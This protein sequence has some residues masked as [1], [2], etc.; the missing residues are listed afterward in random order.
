MCLVGLYS[1]VSRLTWVGWTDHYNRFKRK[2]DVR[3][4]T[5]S[6][7]FNFILCPY[8][9]QINCTLFWMSCC[10]ILAGAQGKQF[11]LDE[12]I[13]WALGWE[14]WAR[15]CCTGLLDSGWAMRG[16]SAEWQACIVW[17][18]AWL[19]QLINAPSSISTEGV[20]Q[21]SVMRSCFILSHCRRCVL[22]EHVGMGTS[23]SVCVFACPSLTASVSQ[24]LRR[25]SDLRN[26]LISTHWWRQ[27]TE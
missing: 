16:N 22:T 14:S 8:F 18:M 15:G 20:G 17:P 13:C 9:R 25:G 1:R 11:W 27:P 3:S 21:Q 23:L 2:V 5:K 4:N 12:P 10:W 24:T 19:A 26:H 6:C 7:L